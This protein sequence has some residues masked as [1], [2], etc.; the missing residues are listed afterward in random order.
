MILALLEMFEPQAD[1]LMPSQ[2]TCKEDSKK[3][4]IS[5]SFDALVVGRLPKRMALV[6]S[7]PVAEPHTQLLDTFY[8]AN[9]GREIGTEKATIGGLIRQTAYSA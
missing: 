6:G 7:Q 4:S 1:S 5:L 2:S 3:G 8:T 9:T